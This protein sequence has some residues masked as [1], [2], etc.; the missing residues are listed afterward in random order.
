[1][2]RLLALSGIASVNIGAFID[3]ITASNVPR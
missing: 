2:R 3:F 1:M